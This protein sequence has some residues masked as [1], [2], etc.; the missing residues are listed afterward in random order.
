MRVTPNHPVLTVAS[1][2]TVILRCHR[3]NATIGW[4]VNETTLGSST[5]NE[6][7]FNL[8]SHSFLNGSQ[9]Y[10]LIFTV[11]ESYSGISIKCIA[12]INIVGRNPDSEETSSIGIIVQGIIIIISCIIYMSAAII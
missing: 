4:S 8:T 5:F 12:F 3:P 2:E 9:V 6:L 10:L 11:N 7:I 1:G